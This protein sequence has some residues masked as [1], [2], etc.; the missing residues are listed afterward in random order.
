MPG[1]ARRRQSPPTTSTSLPSATKG[2][3]RSAAVPEDVR[4]RRTEVVQGGLI[5]VVESRRHA[6]VTEG[7][8]GRLP[9]VVSRKRVQW[10]LPVGAK[11]LP[12]GKDKLRIPTGS[13]SRLRQP[14]SSTD[15]KV[16]VRQDSELATLSSPSS[17]ATRKLSLTPPPTPRISRLP[18]PDLEP[19]ATRAFCTCCGD[20]F[21]PK[22]CQG[23]SELGRHDSVTNMQPYRPQA[24]VSDNSVYDCSLV[25]RS[26]T[27]HLPGI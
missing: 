23:C 8:F 26:N 7:S 13:D 20:F 24:R 25:V 2:M 15:A 19:M 9:T 27:R 14:C 18:S 3:D 6:H 1:A 17:K 11:A 5:V 21:V 16:V 4:Y 22:H 12:G 10:E